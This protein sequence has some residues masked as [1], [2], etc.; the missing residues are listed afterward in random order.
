MDTIRLLNIKDFQLYNE[1]QTGVKD[2]Y[3]LRIFDQLVTSSHQ[4]LYGY[5]H[6]QQL[7]SVA[8]F[9]YFPGGNVMLGRLR[10][11]QRFRHQGHSTQLLRYLVD[12][13]THD[14]QVT[15]IGGYTQVTNTPAKNILEKLSF[16]YV[17]TYYNFPALSLQPFISEHD[18]VWDDITHTKEKQRAIESLIKEGVRSFPYDAYYPF[19]LTKELISD[20]KLSAL[21]IFQ[22]PESKRYLLIDKDFKGEPLL[23]IRYFH[24]DLFTS[25]GL[26]KTI[27]SLLKNEPER[28]PW[29]NLS[30][31]Q[32]N[33]LT[34]KECFRTEEGWEL[35]GTFI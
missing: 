3:M 2:D 21:K 15:F 34:H 17:D 31:E 8:G 14:R 23:N 9:T 1:M 18:V 25:P 32:M 12:L 16:S 13:L 11:D 19:P 10:S 22:S 33:Q 27:S 30:I 24:D 6:D 28:L 20:E 35:Y 7:V 26:F 29:F 5:F 4:Y